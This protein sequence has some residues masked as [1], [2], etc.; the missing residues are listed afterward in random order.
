MDTPA[1]VKTLQGEI[2]NSPRSFERIYRFL[3]SS[4]YAVDDGIDLME[5]HPETL[6][7]LYYMIHS[8]LPELDYDAR[9]E[10][11]QKYRSQLSRQFVHDVQWI[12]QDRGV[13]SPKLSRLLDECRENRYMV[14]YPAFVRPSSHN[15]RDVGMGL[16]S[17]LPIQ[18]GQLVFQFTGTVHSPPNFSNFLKKN[19]RRQEYCIR[20]F[21]GTREYI[22]NP[23]ANADTEVDSTHFAAFMNEPSPPPWTEG[24]I[25]RYGVRNVIVRKY[26][27]GMYTVEY[28]DGRTAA[29]HPSDLTNH[30]HLPSMDRVFESNC[31]WYDFPVPLSDL[32]RPTGYAREGYE[33][34]RT[35][36]NE[37]VLRWSVAELTKAFSVF[38]DTAGVYRIG[39]ATLPQHGH[40]IFLK[41]H[42]FEGLER[43]GLVVRCRPSYLLVRHTVRSLSGWRLPHRVVAGKASFCDR[44]KTEDDPLCRVCRVVPF[45]CVYACKDVGMGD[46]FLC[47]YSS[48]IKSRGHPCREPL[49]PETMRPRWDQLY[50]TPL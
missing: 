7:I 23:L 26:E 9:K 47:L 17:L 6:V 18:R 29:V 2:V 49:T 19:P 46:E 27:E 48:R 28:A 25:V 42:V 39:P 14:R 12:T 50:D 37:C 40:L 35:D 13:P 21:H 22:I 24:D 3:K 10:R 38:S 11:W 36:A 45:P 15:G 30:P 44:C 1:S 31:M 32:Y 41:E 16:Y 20:S 43:Y 34:E 5:V 33:Y 4:G 8:D